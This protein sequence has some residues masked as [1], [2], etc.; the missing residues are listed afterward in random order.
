MVGRTGLKKHTLCASTRGKGG[1]AREKKKDLLGGKVLQA[2]KQSPENL[3][4]AKD[5]LTE[6]R[7]ASHTT[8]WGHLNV[9]EMLK[10]GVGP[11]WPGLP[12]R[13]AN[14][15]EEGGSCFRSGG[16]PFAGEG[17]GFIL[18]NPGSLL[19]PDRHPRPPGQGGGDAVR[20]VM[21]ELA[22][23]YRLESALSGGPEKK[24]QI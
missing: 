5:G 10:G 20:K 11:H 22:L 14:A 18:Q 7:P 2:V 12:P 3:L 8:Q 15:L 16:K 6:K 23:L 13:T 24:G 9:K 4:D 21:P 19:G 17:P 1:E